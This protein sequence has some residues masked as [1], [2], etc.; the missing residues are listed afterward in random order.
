MNLD[1]FD[2]IA[3]EIL[4]YQQGSDGELT[5]TYLKDVSLM[6]SLVAAV[7]EA[8]VEKHLQAERKL[9]E[10]AI[11]YDHPN[12]ARYNTYQKSYLLHLK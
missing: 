3:K 4:R 11:S 12:Y 10:F 8:D 6:L 5:V 9:S 2:F 7:R 1:E